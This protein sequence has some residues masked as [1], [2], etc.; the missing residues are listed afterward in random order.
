MG[1]LLPNVHDLFLSSPLLQ[2][3]TC[4]MFQDKDQDIMIEGMRNRNRALER[5]VVA[6]RLNPR[7]EWKVRHTFIFGLEVWGM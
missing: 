4:D 2:M 1:N 7:S 5:D 3:L 6:V